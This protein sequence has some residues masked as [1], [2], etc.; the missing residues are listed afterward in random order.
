MIYRL[1]ADIVVILH[2]LFIVFVVFGGLLLWWRR[3][4]VW[5]HVPAVIWG[6]VLSLMDWV[7]PL[8]PLENRLR[9]MAGQD[10]YPG[11]F[12]DHYLLPMIYPPGLSHEMQ[13]WIGLAVLAWN[14]LFYLLVYYCYTVRAQKP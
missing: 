4:V 2:L 5:L 12:V 13:L 1:L 9:W 7:C 10:G 11:G 3:A 8:T 6:G 14:V